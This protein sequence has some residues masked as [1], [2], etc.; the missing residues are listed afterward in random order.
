MCLD[1]SLVQLGPGRPS[2]PEEPAAVDS[3]TARRHAEESVAAIV[4]QLG[5]VPGQT[6]IELDSSHGASWLPSFVDAGLEAVPE[7]GT[8]DLVVDVHHLMHA[9]DLN[10]VITTH[11][12]RLKTGG[13]LVC[14]FFHLGALVE[15][16][17][18]DTIRHGHFAYLSVIALE[19]LLARHALTL[20]DALPVN[21]YGGSVR[22][23]I[24]HSADAPEPSPSVAQ[25]RGAESTAGVDRLEVLLGLGAR[26][27]EITSSLRGHLESAQAAGRT[28]AGYG[29]PS[30]APVLLAL[31]QVDV[32]LLPFTVDLAPQKHGCRVP[33][34]AIPIHP[35]DRLLSERPDEVVILTWD[36]ADEV[37]RQLAESSAGSG[38][39]PRLYAPL[40]EPRLFALPVE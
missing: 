22:A 5:L 24:T 1:C 37:A 9:E 17:L 11:V 34:T 21:V 29:A 12:R 25:L 14:E 36:I 2:V 4:R 19:R 28:V 33:G 7:D 35:V 23:V 26:G 32:D 3:R 31:A 30:K 16:R 18:I 10:S 40:P 20:V 8:A 15:Q 39:S 27:R 38:W 6:V 13:H